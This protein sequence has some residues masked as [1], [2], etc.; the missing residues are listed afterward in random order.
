M[1]AEGLETAAGRLVCC[2]WTPKAR[3]AERS[4]RLRRTPMSCGDWPPL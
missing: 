3:A 2:H 4:F 1:K